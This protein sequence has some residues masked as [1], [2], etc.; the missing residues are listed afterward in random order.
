MSI[1]KKYILVVLVFHA[2]VLIGFGHAIAV[3]GLTIFFAP[4]FL[5]NPNVIDLLLLKTDRL[6]AIGSLSLVGYISLIIACFSKGRTRNVLYVISIVTLWWSIAYL[7]VRR[8]SW[9][10]IYSHPVFYVPFLITSL[11]P[12]FRRKLGA[13]VSS[14]VSNW[15]KNCTQHCIG[16]MAAEGTKFSI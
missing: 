1:S 9:Q 16:V 15:K 3:L 2:L 14:W 5:S 4:D 10:M 11:I 12:F 6:P 8:D 7:I 13:K